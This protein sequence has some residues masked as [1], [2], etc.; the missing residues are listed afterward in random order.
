MANVFQLFSQDVLIRLSDGFEFDDQTGKDE[1]KIQLKFGSSRNFLIKMKSSLFNPLKG[2]TEPLKVKI[3]FPK[4]E[5]SMIELTAIES[6]DDTNFNIQMA[7]HEMLKLVL[8]PKIPD[9]KLKNTENSAYIKA[10]QGFSSEF[11]QPPNEAKSDNNEQIKLSIKHWQEWGQHYIRSFEFAHLFE[12]CLNFKSP[13]MKTYRSAKFDEIVDKL[14]DIFCTLP[15]PTPSGIDYDKNLTRVTTRNI[16]DFSGGCI[17]E[18]C[19]V[20][21]QNGCVKNLSDLNKNDILEDGSKLVCLIKSK[22]T[23]R[24]VKLNDLVITP[25]HPIHFEGKWQF[26]IDVYANNLKKPLPNPFFGLLE[27]HNSKSWNVCN[28]VLEKN[29]IIEIENFQ[30]VTLG[31]GF[32]EDVVKHDYY[33]TNRCIEDLIKISGWDDG[34]IILDNYRLIRDENMLVSGMVLEVN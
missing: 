7:R 1:K 30:V 20:K 24:L 22:Y 32:E 13:S 2:K 16:M 34:L 14:T 5:A 4:Q 10:V 28:I 19:K 23:G 21:L 25:Y 15:L 17:L 3:G 29:H 26:P 18:S 31:H 11:N 27:N 8:N 9:V 33:G 6:A 12:Q